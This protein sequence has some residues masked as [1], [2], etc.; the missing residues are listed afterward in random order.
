MARFDV[1]ANSGRNKANAPFLVDVQSNYL[2]GLSTRVVVPL[3]RLAAFPPA[4]LPADLLP[5]FQVQGIECMFYPAFIGAV[6]MSE[7][8]GS[9]GSLRDER[10][11]IIAAL[12]R[13][14]GG[15]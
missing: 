6:S 5:V 10:D 9:V 2:E 4:K 14:T 15:F 13:L 1:Y 7:L 12:D 11:K 3:L 8:G